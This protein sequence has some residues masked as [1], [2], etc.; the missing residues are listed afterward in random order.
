VKY[1]GPPDL[2]GGEDPVVKYGGPPDLD[3]GE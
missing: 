1:G 2:D 3:G